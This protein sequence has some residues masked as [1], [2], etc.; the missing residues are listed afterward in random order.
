MKHASMNQAPVKHTPAKQAPMK[1]FVCAT[2]LVLCAPFALAAPPSDAQV[3]QLLEVM[4]AKKTVE[5]MVP[6]VQAMQ[7]QMVEQITAG[8]EITPEQKQK[9]DSIVYKSNAQML[10]MVSWNNMQPLYREIYRQTFSGEDMDAMIGFY[11][12]PAGQNLLDKMP[13]LMQNTMTAMQKVMVPMLQQMQKDI[14]AE[15]AKKEVA[16]AAADGK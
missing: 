5:A 11:G 15:A 1:R 7:R 2:L 4:R 14:E 10:S 6:Q 8:Q 3:D 13:Q 16:P 12:S 9:L